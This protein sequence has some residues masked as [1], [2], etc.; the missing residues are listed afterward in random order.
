MSATTVNQQTLQGMEKHAEEVPTR[1]NNCLCAVDLRGFESLDDLGEMLL[2]DVSNVCTTIS[3]LAA[4]HGGVRIGRALVCRLKGFVWWIKDHQR[5]GQV[6]DENDWNL[7]TCK[8]STD[9]AD[10]EEGR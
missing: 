5:R 8:V 6:A 7:Q 3:E 4:N 2:K 1:W 10:T 9:H